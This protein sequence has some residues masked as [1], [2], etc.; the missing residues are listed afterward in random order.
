M[1]AASLAAIR[2]ARLF[3]SAGQVTQCF[4][5]VIEANGPDVFLGERCLIRT[6][7]NDALRAEVIGLRNGKVL[8]MALGD[9]RGVR[10]GCEVIG[11]KEAVQV[12]VDRALL[13]RVIDAF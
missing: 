11:T 4:G 7:V 1:S 3:R 2:S 9:I 12:R 8:L 6:G 13:G 5:L 10:A